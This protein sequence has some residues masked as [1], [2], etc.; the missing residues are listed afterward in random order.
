MMFRSQVARITI[1]QQTLD[2]RSPHTSIFQIL[3]PTGVLYDY[4]IDKNGINQRGN[5]L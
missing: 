5:A 4:D 2:T 1:T 3:G